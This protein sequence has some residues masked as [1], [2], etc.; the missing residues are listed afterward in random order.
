MISKIFTIENFYGNQSMSRLGYKFKGA[1]G[2]LNKN[3]RNQHYPE[4]L[5]ESNRFC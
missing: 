4:I 5:I 2:E 1:W 3:I